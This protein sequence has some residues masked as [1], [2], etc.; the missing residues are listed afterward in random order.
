[1]SH[2]KIY[3]L[4]VYKLIKSYYNLQLAHYGTQ[5]YAGNFN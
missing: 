3:L 2:I 5:L 4:I 1:M